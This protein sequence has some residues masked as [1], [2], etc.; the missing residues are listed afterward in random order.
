MSDAKEKR[1]WRS[2]QVMQ[3]VQANSAAKFDGSRWSGDRA[4]P[5][6]TFRRW[7]GSRVQIRSGAKRRKKQKERRR[8]MRE[9]L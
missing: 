6:Q 2:Y 4:I 1:G 8:R 5:R 3:E 7:T 9:V